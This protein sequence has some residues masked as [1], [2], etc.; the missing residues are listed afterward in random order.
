MKRFQLLLLDADVVIHIFS[1][2]IWEKLIERC[3]VYLAGTVL[4]EAHFYEDEH[5]TRH[6]F[7][8]RSYADADRITVF[9]MLPSEL[10]SF[11]QRFDPVYLEKLDE[12]ETESLAYLLTAEEDSRICS[13]DKIVF[14]ILGALKMSDRGVSLE[15]VLDQTGLSRQLSQHLTKTYR[16]KWTQRGFQEGM[17]GIGLD[18]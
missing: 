16:E 17:W 7:S 2:G 1:L 9:D 14:R 6:D 18:R 13:A 4:S 3:D 10:T 12:G 8:L 15:E 5:G 11:R